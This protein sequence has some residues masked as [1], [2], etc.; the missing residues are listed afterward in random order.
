MAIQVLTF[1]WTPT[2]G[3][4]IVQ[5]LADGHD[6]LTLG[7]IHH[8]T[9]S[10]VSAVIAF[11]GEHP[12]YYVLTIAINQPEYWPSKNDLAAIRAIANNRGLTYSFEIANT[13]I[14]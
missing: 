11:I 7:H 1:T 14:S 12:E 6:P 4:E 5:Q 10:N 9:F 8:L 3:L 13:V 2:I